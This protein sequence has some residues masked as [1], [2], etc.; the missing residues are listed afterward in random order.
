MSVLH[1]L[2][3]LLVTGLGVSWRHAG[4]RRGLQGTQEYNVRGVLNRTCETFSQFMRAV[5]KTDTI[6][7]P[8]V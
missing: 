7:R 5:L 2:V 3:P 1:R 8:S 4:M 6:M